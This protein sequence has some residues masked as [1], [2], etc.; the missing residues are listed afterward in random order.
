MFFPAFA[1]VL[2]LSCFLSPYLGGV[3]GWVIGYLFK[4]PRWAVPGGILGGTVGGWVG[5]GL[6]ILT[7]S[8]GARENFGGGVVCLLIGT[9]VGSLALALLVSRSNLKP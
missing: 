1:I 5:I 6:Y 3:T 9:F 8:P 7:D 2:V 4:K